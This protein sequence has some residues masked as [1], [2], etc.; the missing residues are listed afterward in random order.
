MSNRLIERLVRLGLLG[1]G[2]S[3][4][5]AYFTYPQVALISQAT[6]QHD[7]ALF[8][9][10]RLA[11]IAHALGTDPRHLF[12]ANIFFPGRG[13]LAYSDAMLLPGIVLAPLHWL[14]ADP[15]T[16]YNLVLL[17]SFVLCALAGTHLGWRLTERWDAGII[18][19]LIFGFAPH[20]FEHFEHLELQL[21]WWMPL[22]FVALERV[23]ATGTSRWWA[24]LS[25]LLAFQVLSC[26]Y[27]T[28]FLLVCLTGSALVML[29]T[30]YGRTPKLNTRG[31]LWLSVPVCVILLYSGPY[32]A[33]QQLVGERSRAE[34]ADYSA[35]PRNF[36]A[37]HSSNVLYGKLTNHMG[38]G[39]RYLF[40][41]SIALALA[42]IG[43]LSRRRA[44]VVW[45]LVTLGLAVDLC[46]GMNGLLY[47]LLY[48]NVSVFRGLRVP[49]RAAILVMLALAILAGLG[50]E[51]L[52]TT[53]RNARLRTS[54]LI[55][56][57]VG[58]IVEFQ[59]R[60]Q[61]RPVEKPA[62]TYR[63]F[64]NTPEAV[65]LELPVTTSD[66]L[67]ESH[68]AAYMYYSTA[69]WRKL[70]NGY[71]GF[72][73]ESYFRLLDQLR[74]FPDPSSL[75]YLRSTGATHILLHRAD[76]TGRLDYESTI[77]ELRGLGASVIFRH[78][79]PNDEI[80]VFAVGR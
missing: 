10:W 6:G 78:W 60:L 57:T 58:I 37:A 79:L 38:Q 42:L 17:V 26:I 56:L 7:D 61:L 22:A 76:W 55:V 32:R 40:P 33:N 16:L 23:I 36:L 62:P 18:A 72:Y 24:A 50:I 12:D 73:P 5:I 45:G 25:G 59:P 2:F 66:R 29:V 31:M 54:L 14:G 4:L 49:A 53:I 27:D 21:N 19:G 65:L 34:V 47:P 52:M 9:V 8:S 74:S 11:W 28:V 68:D 64:R 75:A 67:F 51:L 39:E 63:F 44:T 43:V 15:L 48:D 41:G 70:L 30:H 1:V 69:H 35:V 20:R 77:T 3:A 13:T 71:S 80:T 46:L